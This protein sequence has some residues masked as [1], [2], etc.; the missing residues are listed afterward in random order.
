MSEKTELPTPHKLRKAREDGQVAHSKDFTQT[1]LVVALF[2]YMLG[3]AEAIVRGMGEMMLLPLSF[4]QMEF[5]MAANALVERLLR[6]M[7]EMLA[8]FLGI[9]IGLGLFVELA[10]TG[11][12]FSFK[13]L[14]PSGKKLNVVTNVKNIFAKKNLVEFIKSN[15]KI[16]LLAT[17][18]YVLLRSSL[19]TLLTLPHGGLA[20]VAV[21]TATL[22]KTMMLHVSLGYVAISLG[23]FIWQRYQHVQQLKMSKE[24]IKQEHK[25]AEGDPHIKHKRRELHKEM[26]QR[27]E[28]ENT[29]AASVVV[30]NPTH[31]AVALAY[32]PGVT[33]LPVVLAKGEDA[34]AFRIA[35]IA[36]QCGIPVLQ[37]IPLARALMADARLNEYIPSELVEPVAELL[38]LVNEMRNQE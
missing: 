21:A 22:L 17:V 19:P 29:R 30:T 14:A 24:E 8:P 33:P 31:L 28:A 27:N 5:E 36:R 10:Q 37:N 7:L 34:Q 15:L 26:L 1:V 2:G 11:M 25:E 6:Q 12:M 20:A 16:L 38:R 13:A 35:A 23:D 9:V 3:N 32:E 4:L 18:V